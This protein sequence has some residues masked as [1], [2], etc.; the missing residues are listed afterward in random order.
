MQ[1][2]SVV[3]IVHF[4]STFLSVYLDANEYYHRS[5]SRLGL[6]LTGEALRRLQLSALPSCHARE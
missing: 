5:R 6:L 3:V 2:R 1:I 4:T